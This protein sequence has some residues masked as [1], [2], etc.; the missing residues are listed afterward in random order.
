MDART[1]PS[2][3][4]FGSGG[5]DASATQVWGLVSDAAELEPARDTV[6]GH[7]VGSGGCGYVGANCRQR[8]DEAVCLAYSLISSKTKAPVDPRSRP[9]VGHTN[10][11]GL[12]CATR[13]WPQSGRGTSSRLE[14]S[15]VRASAL[16]CW[17]GEACRHAA[18]C[19]SCQA[20]WSHHQIGGASACCF[21]AASRSE[22][23]SGREINQC[24]G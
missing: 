1:C 17:R 12:G 7:A 6:I 16:D 3:W 13:V 18:R 22:I 21:E 2:A 15:V 9:T 4:S 20:D 24:G 19:R 8:A 14:N 23:A 10:R 5:A 11:C